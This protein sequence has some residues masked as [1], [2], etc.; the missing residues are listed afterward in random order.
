MFWDCK[1]YIP[2]DGKT[3][4]RISQEFTLRH[5]RNSTYISSITCRKF[6]YLSCFEFRDY[7]WAKG[8]RLAMFCCCLLYKAENQ[9]LLINTR[10][11]L[12]RDSVKNLA[13]TERSMLDFPANDPDIF[14]YSLEIIYILYYILWYL[15]VAWTKLF[16]VLGHTV[17][18]T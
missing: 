12:C 3:I 11:L 7:L 13:E 4:F 1:Q 18:L 16:V 14:S 15:N 8:I 17:V 9:L 10:K 2:R 5:I 6:E